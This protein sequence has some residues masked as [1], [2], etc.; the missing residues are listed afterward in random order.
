MEL[1]ELLALL[2]SRAGLRAAPGPS[3]AAAPRPRYVTRAARIA[4]S[5]SSSRA[6]ELDLDEAGFTGL[7]KPVEALALVGARAGLRLV[8]RVQLLA[9]EE[10]AVAR[11]DL[12]ALGD[13]LLADTNGAPFLGALEEVSL[14]LRLELRRRPDSRDA[15]IG[16]GIY[17]S[18]EPSRPTRSTDRVAELVDRERLADHVAPSGS[19][20]PR[21]ACQQ[22]DR[23][24]VLLDRR[25]EPEA[26]VVAE[27]NVEEDRVD[28][29]RL[30]HGSGALDT[31]GLD[32]PISLELQVDATE[33]P[34]R[35]IVVDDQHRR[36]FPSHRV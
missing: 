10:L 26:V 18:E 25:Q 27:V 24:A 15:H 17:P 23:G 21:T 14:E 13:L 31:L 4:F 11:D 29:L 34:E 5:S 2:R 8:Q 12:G 22:C 33:E 32:D 16:W 20:T 28:A 3:E 35:G 9:R 36:R 30:E 19:R 1:A 6:L 7:A